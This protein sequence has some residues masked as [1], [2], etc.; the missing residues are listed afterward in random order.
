MFPVLILATIAIVYWYRVYGPGSGSGGSAIPGGGGSS[1]IGSTSLNV[2]ASA[3]AKFEN[4][5]PAYNNPLAIQG[6]GDTGQTAPNGLGIYS[7]YSAG[8]NAG[9]GLL[10]SYA[11]RFPNYTVTQILSRWATG[12]SDPSTLSAAD[13]A[14]VNNEARLVGS[15]LGVDPNSATIAAIS[16]PIDG[17]GDDSGGDSGSDSTDDTGTTDDTSDDSDP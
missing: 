2:M 10:Q 16:T 15:A 13:Q 17:G 12:S 6:S 4:A 8:Y 3:M 5:N 11:N 1:T 14:K 9:V 7:S